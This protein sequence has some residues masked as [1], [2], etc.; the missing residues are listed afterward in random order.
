MSFK[1]KLNE[2]VTIIALNQTGTIQD[3]AQYL[4]GKDM[5][6]LHYKAADGRAITTWWAEDL[7]HSES[8]EAVR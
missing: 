7:L 8:A 1:F 2:T 5:Y 6:Q 3:R 4:T